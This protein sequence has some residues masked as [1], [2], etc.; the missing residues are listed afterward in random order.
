MEERERQGNISVIGFPRSPPIFVTLNEH[1]PDP[2]ETGARNCGRKLTFVYRKWC[3][4]YAQL[5]SHLE[6]EI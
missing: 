3:Q 2:Q 6:L 4:D 1:K 5:D